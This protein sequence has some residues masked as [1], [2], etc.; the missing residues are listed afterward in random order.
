MYVCVCVC[1][2]AC[3]CPALLFAL[4]SHLLN[5]LFLGAVTSSPV[6]LDT[7]IV[8]RPRKDQAWHHP[9]SP[10]ELGWEILTQPDPGAGGQVCL[11]ETPLSV[12][13]LR[14][15]LTRNPSVARA[16]PV[17]WAEGG[18]RSHPDSAPQKRLLDG[19]GRSTGKG[20]EGG[21]EGVGA[22]LRLRD[23]SLELVIGS[24]GEGQGWW[25]GSLG[26]EGKSPLLL[27][28]CGVCG[29]GEW[30]GWRGKCW[31]VRTLS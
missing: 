23:S 24:Q 27:H 6:I 28:T 9:P 19:G 18:G 3:A 2:C 5:Q 26:R 11:R 4:P 13:S 12:V 10:N 31:E 22:P 7:A 30:Q 8:Q 21:W 14:S 17:L 20:A 25:E 29:P 1:V 16:H 15:G